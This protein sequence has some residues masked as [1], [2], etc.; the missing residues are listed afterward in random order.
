MSALHLDE[1]IDQGI[2]CLTDSELIEIDFKL[3][4]SVLFENTEYTYTSINLCLNEKLQTTKQMQFPG[5]SCTLCKNNERK[6]NIK[7][8]VQIISICQLKLN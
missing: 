1:S 5:H 8:Y 7:I 4:R 2:E 3:Y 6:L